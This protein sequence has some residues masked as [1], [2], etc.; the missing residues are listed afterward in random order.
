MNRIYIIGP[1]GSGKTTLAADLAAALGLP[2]VELDAIHW[3]PNWQEPL[4]EEF[5]EQVSTALAGDSWAVDGNYGKA[6]DI[7][8]A[9]AELVVWLDFPLWV[10]LPRLFRRTTTRIFKRELL[11]GTNRETFREAFLSKDSLFLYVIK[12]HDRRRRQFK[13][14]VSN[15]KYQHIEFVRLRSPRQVRH[16]FEAFTSSPA[17]PAG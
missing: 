3:R 17:S 13:A 14:L 9:R 5:R 15:E 10:I 4:V 16:W 2:H 11:W 8:L 1:G 7:V 12:T 6:R